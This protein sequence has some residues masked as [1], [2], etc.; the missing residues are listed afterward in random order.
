MTKRNYPVAEAAERLDVSCHSIYSWIKPYAN[1][2]PVS[3][4]TDLQQ[5]EIRQL[6][7]ELRWVTEE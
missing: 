1:P 3:A 4:H 5:D 7:A 6:K 2:V